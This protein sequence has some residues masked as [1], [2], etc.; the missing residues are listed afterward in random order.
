MIIILVLSEDCFHVQHFFSAF[1]LAMLNSFVHIW[2]YSY[3]ALAAF[4]PHMQKYLWWKKYMTV[5]QLVRNLLVFKACIC[6][7][8]SSSLIFAGKYFVVLCLG[9]N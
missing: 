5:L 6:K 7:V 1:F 9:R 4:G 8:F 2:M 3:Y